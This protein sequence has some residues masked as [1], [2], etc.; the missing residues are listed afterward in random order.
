MAKS[1]EEYP[2]QVQAG[3]LAGT[4]VLLGAFAGW[5]L[6]WPRVQSCFAERRSIQAQHAEN[7]AHR[8]FELQRPL[9]QKRLKEAETRLDDLRSKVPDDVDPAGLVRLVHDAESASGVHVRSLAMQPQ[10][11]SNVYVELPAKLHVDGEYDALVS[12]F[13][14]LG[15]SPRITNVSGLALSTPTTAGGGAF[16][17]APRETVAADFVLST[18]CNAAATAV[19]PPAPAKK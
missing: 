15:A 3:I 6:V 18:Y 5:Y 19:P 1:L 11:N 10:V 12:F 14:H 17:L 9:Y 4:A 13:D 7:V 16:T 2:R 8:S